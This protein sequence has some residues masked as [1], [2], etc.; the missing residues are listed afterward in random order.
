MQKQLQAQTENNSSA[1][2]ER[3]VVYS[4]NPNNSNFYLFYGHV[5]KKFH[6]VPFMRDYRLVDIQYILNIKRNKF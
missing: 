6:L 2:I 4:R 3:A 1:A 5:G